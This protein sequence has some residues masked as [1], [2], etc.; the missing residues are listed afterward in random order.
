MADFYNACVCVFYY[1]YFLNT[2]S[3]YVAQVGLELVI[4]FYLCS[5]GIRGKGVETI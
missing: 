5:A 4:L 2:L 1:E 3:F